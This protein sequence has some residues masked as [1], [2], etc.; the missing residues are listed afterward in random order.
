[1]AAAPRWKV[2]DSQGRYQA[3]CKELEAAASLMG[4]YGDGASIHDGHDAHPVWVE[5]HEAFS[6][7]ESYDGVVER[8][9]EKIAARYAARREAQIR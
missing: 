5:G 3:A 9:A 6:A 7:M 2:Y 4:F 1:M 8:V